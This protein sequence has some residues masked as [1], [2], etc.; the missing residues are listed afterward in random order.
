MKALLSSSDHRARCGRI[1]KCG[2]AWGAA[3]LLAACTESPPV[4]LS[5]AP[6]PPRPGAS[7]QASCASA[8]TPD[9][10]LLPVAS[11]DQHPDSV[12]YNALHVP[13]AA[14]GFSYYD[15]L[16]G[17]RI[18]KVTSPTFPQSNTGSGHDYSDGPNQVS[19]G[20]GTGNNTHTLLITVQGN[21]FP[22]YLVNFTRDVGFSSATLI[23]AQFQPSTQL[24]FSFSSVPGQEQ[25]AYVIHRDTLKR[26]N[27]ATMVEDT[28]G[29]FP[30]IPPFP[31]RGWLQHD[32][33]D[34]WFVGL[35]RVDDNT[36]DNDTIAFAWNSRTNT[37]F[38]DSEPWL[39]EPRLERDGRYVALTNTNT[40]F[41][42]WDL[43]TSTLGP[44]QSSSTY[45]LG[46]NANLRGQWVTTDVNG[47]G[48]APPGLARYYPSGGQIAMTRFLSN[49]A[50]YAVHH[51]GSWVQS[52]VEL[53]GDLNKQWSFL[54]GV[55]D[56]AYTVNALWKQAIG[57][58]RSDGS[59]ARLFAHHY[60]AHP[61][62]YDDPYA[63]PSPDG[64][65]VIF[66][67]NMNG[68]GRYDLFV[69]EMPL[70]GSQSSSTQNVVWTNL[71]NVTA[72]G[73][74]VTKTS[75]GDGWSDAGPI[76]SQTITSGDGYVEFQLSANVL[77]AAAGLSK[78]NTDNTR[79]DI[80]FALA[81]AG[82]AELEVR[83]NGVYK[84]GTPFDAAAI[85]RVEVL[86]GVVQYKKNGSVFYTST[87][88][89]TYPLLLDSWIG[90]L[91]AS[92]T[93]AVISGLLN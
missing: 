92:I 81:R 35:V 51:S 76:S 37:F 43:A 54:S 56:D 33:N 84:G 21:Y 20:W 79:D 25:I 74:S 46:H 30:F 19:R 29:N 48:P 5:R 36:M 10:C 38:R 62:Y 53:G 45:W 6:S 93:S 32:K 50:G 17:V 22:Y 2:V 23:P 78:G 7:L 63:Q 73:N 42:L 49:S 83:E 64:K 18:W 91:N 34:E 80:D 52:D 88:A 57:I 58:V 70:S 69:A 68:S 3:L 47:S 44:V 59:D 11:A 87:V 89:P 71:T 60:S 9:P 85:F 55:E 4:G 86:N 26:V 90:T 75:G 40:T 72:N 16:S 67:S 15:R 31:M 41:R 27:T 14:P 8:G 1:T 66:T 61:G 65:V 39:N 13:D 77:Y 24:A 82:G 12:W 28:T